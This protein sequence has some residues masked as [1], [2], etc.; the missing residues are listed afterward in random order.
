MRPRADRCGQA[1]LE[2][3]VLLVVAVGLLAIVAVALP[4]IAPVVAAAL[5]GDAPAPIAASADDAIAG[6]G[7]SVT[8]ARALLGDAAVVDAARR[9]TAPAL[10]R[11]LRVVP[12][13]G[14]SRGGSV[15]AVSTADVPSVRLVTA[16][17]EEHYRRHGTTGGERVSAAGASIAWDGA[18][19]LARRL[20]RPL[21]VAVGA[22]HALVDDRGLPDPLPP[23]TRADDVVVCQ[24]VRLVAANPL[25]N[26]ATRAWHV[27]ILRGGRIVVDA[28]SA[29][30]K[31]CG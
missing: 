16:D 9:R 31:A 5:N 10:A 21:G 26:P 1:T 19:I 18:E 4:R 8:A 14:L 2:L 22:I 7:F 17:D 23:G 3:L 11:G 15:R 24:P 30:G 12:P 20:A 27:V 29:D 13:R 6:R 28:L 25:A